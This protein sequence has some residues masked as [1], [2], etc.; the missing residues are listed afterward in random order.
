MW[1]DPD[2][3]IDWPPFSNLILNLKDAAAPSL[4][5]LKNPFIYGENS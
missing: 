4:A 3:G 5:N 1:N 2:I